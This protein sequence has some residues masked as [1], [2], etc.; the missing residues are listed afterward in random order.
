MSPEGSSITFRRVPESLRRDMERPLRRFAGALQKSVARGRAFDCL[1]TN[2]A[3]LRRLNREFRGKD[4]PTDVLSF[5]AA[6][7]FSEPRPSGSGRASKR[8]GDLAISLPR[9][10]AQAAAFGHDVGQ[11]LR[12]LMLHGVLH[13]VG[14]DHETDAGRMARAEKRWRIRLGLPAG[15][16]ERVEA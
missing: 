15:L 6:P 1:I 9:A 12:I 14:M 3:E 10:R 2:D 8:L 16:I 4:A 7:P 13:L 5:P 11:E